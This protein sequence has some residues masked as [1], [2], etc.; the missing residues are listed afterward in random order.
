MHTI[1]PE[2]N[3]VVEYLCVFI[4]GG[5]AKNELEGRE[6]GSRAHSPNVAGYGCWEGTC[7]L[8]HCR[9]RKY[10]RLPETSHG[11]NEHR[12][13]LGYPKVGISFCTWPRPSSSSES[14]GAGVEY[15][16][17]D[18]GTAD[19]KSGGGGNYRRDVR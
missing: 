8:H 16:V 10:V 1:A 14:R 3:A 9:G 11:S 15:I 6:G 19:K 18:V 17:Q 12:Q 13:V 5:S 7:A 4:L 2:A